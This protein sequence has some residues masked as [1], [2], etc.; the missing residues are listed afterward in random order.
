MENLKNY[1]NLIDLFDYPTYSKIETILQNKKYLSDNKLI[2]ILD[3]IEKILQNEG[4]FKLQEMYTSAFDLMPI[5]YPYISY[6]IYYDSFERNTMMIEIRELYN[7][8]NFHLD[9]ERNE[10]PDNLFVM[11]KF[12]QLYPELWITIKDKYFVKAFENFVNNFKNVIKSST[13]VY[14]EFLMYFIEI[15]LGG[16]RVWQTV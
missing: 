13:N 15:V 12:L 8:Y 3:K 9:V 10:L 7:Q 1:L 14:I 5:F 11:L 4:I 2:K 16:E 6:H